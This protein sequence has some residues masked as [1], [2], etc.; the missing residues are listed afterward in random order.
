MTKQTPNTINVFTTIARNG[1]D[2]DVVVTQTYRFVPANRDDDED[3]SFDF[4]FVGA[5]LDLPEN[6]SSD[7]RLTAAELAQV[8][9]WLDSDDGVERL[10]C[11]ADH[12]RS[13]HYCDY[14]NEPDYQFGE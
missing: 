1:A 4:T 8:T 11:E 9:A 2:L 5:E 13:L 12:H 6:D 7:R 3:S 14:A 10:N